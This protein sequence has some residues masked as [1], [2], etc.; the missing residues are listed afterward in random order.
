M[1]QVKPEAS[2][3]YNLVIDF[4]YLMGVNRKSPIVTPNILEFR[5]CI[6]LEVLWPQ[7]LIHL[8]LRIPYYTL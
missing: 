2:M 8:D 4:M 5:Y 6:K 7:A 1:N 3:S